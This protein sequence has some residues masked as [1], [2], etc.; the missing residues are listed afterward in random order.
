MLARL[1]VPILPQ[2]ADTTA[3]YF[4]GNY[5]FGAQ[6]YD[7]WPEF[8]LVG[9][10]SISSLALTGTGLLSDPFAA[11][12][13]PGTE[14]NEASFS[15]TAVADTTNVGRYT[16]P[17]AS[18]PTGTGTATTFNVVIYQG[19]GD[20]LIWMDEDTSS[21]RTLQQPG[22]LTGIPALRKGKAVAK[23][24]RKKETLTGK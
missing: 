24:R 23:A 8:D 13:T 14:Y 18:N 20:Q 10:G 16:I 21:L 3:A 5:A 7:N 12:G 1:E 15:G 17:L 9:Q 4:T 6:A 19:S 2:T 22:S 11:F